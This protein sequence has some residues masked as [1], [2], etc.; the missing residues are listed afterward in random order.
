MIHSKLAVNGK[1]E[2]MAFM[3][4]M[5]L[6]RVPDFAQWERDRGFTIL[7]QPLL[8]HESEIWR[9]TAENQQANLL[10]PNISVSSDVPEGARRIHHG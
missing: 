5:L 8:A 1:L 7:N 2:A 9:A 6:T 3:A 4:R 10:Q